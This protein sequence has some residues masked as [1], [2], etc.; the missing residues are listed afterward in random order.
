M[1]TPNG[2][3]GSNRILIHNQGNSL[4]NRTS[5]ILANR[6]YVDSLPFDGITLNIPATWS[7]LAPG[8]VASY[9][10]IYTNWLAP[11]K[12][13]LK[14]VTHNYVTIVTRLSADPF[15]DWT[16]TI[17]NFVTLADACRDAGLEGIFF[18]NEQYFEQMW[19]YPDN[20]KY[21]ST[22]TLSQYQE[23]YRLRGQQVMQA[24]L[25]QWPNI[26]VIHA[27]QAAESESRTPKT[28]DSQFY[29]VDAWLAGY[30]F[31]GMFAAAPGQLID[32]GE[33]YMYRTI[34]DY[35]ASYA[36][37]KISEPNL[38]PN[39]LI[40]SSIESSWIANLS[41]SFGM[42]DQPWNGGTMTPAIWQSEIT[43]ALNT[44]DYLAWTYT[45]VNDYLTPGG[46]PQVWIDAIWNAR[47]AAGIPA[48][49][50][51]NELEIK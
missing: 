4:S 51:G 41:V 21:S 38:L 10:D 18:D 5:N 2:Y 15:D 1:I 34:A 37:R 14:N 13:Q 48:P 20:V 49:G 24:M 50:S 32:G 23:Q 40:P 16:Q 25:A 47:S 43:N 19:L 39:H 46:V 9:S 7:L 8:N 3:A 22:K 45:D 6:A 36:W 12:G 27:H 35:S 33:E 42:Y 44:A 30:F 11:L 17:A 29:G 28:V 26:K 31:A